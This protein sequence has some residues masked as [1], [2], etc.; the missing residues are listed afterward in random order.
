MVRAI[1]SMPRQTCERARAD[2]HCYRLTSAMRGG[3]RLGGGGTTCENASL[4]TR[5]APAGGGRLR[6]QEIGHGG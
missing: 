1:L 4:V 5:S 3:D 6:A 2:A